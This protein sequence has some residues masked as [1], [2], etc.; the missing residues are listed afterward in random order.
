MSKK[1]QGESTRLSEKPCQKTCKDDGHKE[2]RRPFTSLENAYPAKRLKLGKR[3]KNQYCASRDKQIG[4]PQ[5]PL[6]PRLRAYLCLYL[7]MS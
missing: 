3:I 6:P 5:P 2:R 7:V 1:L 4:L